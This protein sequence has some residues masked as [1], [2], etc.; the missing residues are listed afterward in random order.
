MAIPPILLNQNS[1]LQTVT[2]EIAQPT[3]TQSEIE[4]YHAEI[5]HKILFKYKPGKEPKLLKAT[6]GSLN[7]LLPHGFTFI[8]LQ[9]TLYEK[10]CREK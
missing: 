3:Q 4:F 2:L 1:Q 8:P 10:K 7:P 5:T 9:K 6:L